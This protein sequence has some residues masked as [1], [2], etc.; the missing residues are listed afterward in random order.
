M[1]QNNTDMAA[2]LKSVFMNT[3][4][5]IEGLNGIVNDNSKD[6]R[7]S[8]ASFSK[9][10]NSTGEMMEKINNSIANIESITK[11]LDSTVNNLDE[12][13]LVSIVSNINEI[14]YQLK[15]ISADI[16]QLT[17]D[18]NAPLGIDAARNAGMY[19]IAI[20]TTLGKEYL[21]AADCILQDIGELLTLPILQ[22]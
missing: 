3:A 11:K 5:L 2:R 20:E 7:K 22:P 21:A 13:Q 14:T 15:Q 6:I 4:E 19:C 18:E 1:G 9:T 17:H 12:K 8:V 10:M 16:N